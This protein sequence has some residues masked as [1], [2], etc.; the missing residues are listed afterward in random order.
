L[1]NFNFIDEYLAESNEVDLEELKVSPHFKKKR[2]VDAL[3]FGEL[4]DSKRHGKGIMKYKSGRVYE[5]EWFND[6]R[7]S[8]GYERYP[9][10][11]VYIG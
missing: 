3:Y 11:N 8:R 9:N 10:G 2:Y 1:V 6:L 4:V 7:H 5:G